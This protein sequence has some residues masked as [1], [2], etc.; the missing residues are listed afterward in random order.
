MR[1]GRVEIF[2]HKMHNHFPHILWRYWRPR[3][4]NAIS[5]KETDCKIYKWLWLGFAVYPM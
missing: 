2:L 4:L 1:I 3:W 5:Y